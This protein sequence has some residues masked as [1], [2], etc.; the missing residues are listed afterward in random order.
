MDVR[1]LR[2]FI[3]IVEARSFSRAAELLHVAQPALSHHVRTMESDLGVQL[4][5]RGARGVL[6][7]EAGL[8]LLERAHVV[9]AEISFL[10]DHV[11]GRETRPT[12]DV[13]F[14]MPGT[15][16]EQLGAALIETARRNYP[17]IRIRIAEAMSG[18]VLN[19]LRD[20]EVDIALLYNATDRTGL[21][22]HHA[23]T[24]EIRLF[25]TPR[26][27]GAPGGQNVGLAASLRLPL[28]LPSPGHGLRNLIDAAADSIG[29]HVDP[30]I[31]IDSYR[32]IKHLVDRCLGFGMLPA[33]AIDQETR[34]GT[35]RSWRIARPRLL[36]KIFLGYRADRP[37]STASRAAG[38][39][40]W[41]ILRD[42]VNSKAWEAEWTDQD[43][44]QLYSA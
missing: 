7:T 8:R 42:M 16:S 2:Y 31:E 39:L 19:W 41:S 15:V 27:A 22:M 25:G 14:G 33:M 17:E 36:R 30:E 37:L 20:G 9:D 13:R 29:K 24:E 34:Q 26:I 5:H 38:Q 28:I 44:V 40:S 12:G 23:L 6:P 35:L 18:F 10:Y 11:R 4:L 43:D 21:T 32:Q 3:A 1:Q